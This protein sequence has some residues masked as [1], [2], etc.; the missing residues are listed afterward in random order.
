MINARKI[1][2]FTILSFILSACS[3]SSN[4]DKP[5]PQKD[6]PTCLADI[7]GSS[8]AVALGSAYDIFLSKDSN[9]NIV[10]IDRGEALTAVRNGKVDYTIFDTLVAVTGGLEKKGLEIKFGGVLPR[11]HSLP[12]AKSRGELCGIFNQ[13]LEY[14][15]SSGLYDKIFNKW[16]KSQADVKKLK[17]DI[18]LDSYYTGPIKNKDPLV[19]V[20]TSASYPWVLIESGGLTG[21]QPDIIEY[22]CKWV[23]ITF[24]YVICDFSAVSA[25][26]ETGKGDCCFCPLIKTPESEKAFVWSDP[27]VHVGGVI[28]GRTEKESPSEKLSFWEQMEEEFN[29]NLVK[30]DRWKL[31]LNGLIDTLYISFFSILFAIVVGAFICSMRM[32]R[33]SAINLIARMLINIIRSVPMLVLLMIMFYVVFAASRAGGEFISI[34]C[35]AI[36]FGAYFSEVFRTGIE[37]VS[38]GQ[39]EAGAALG[40]NKYQVFRFI[41]LPQA[42]TRCVPVLK[43]EIITLIKSTSLVGYVAVQDL[44]KAS[45]L[46]RSRTMDAFFLLLIVAL[47]Y[48]LLSWLT[49]LLLDKVQDCLTPKSKRT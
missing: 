39:R 6:K 17:E 45:D 9:L 32:S 33:N 37:S 30:E 40:L 25:M 10:H 18:V 36:Y 5:S 12:F 8:I 28:I 48:A 21:F 44:T 27:Y 31:L 24:E 11:D 34:I 4:D 41:V 13:F 2:I 14:A 38:T 7:K 1:V 46:I 47:V 49:G 20:A 16:T 23:G 29:L 42:L 15:H 26:L 3:S 19:I 43:G 22:F 35:F